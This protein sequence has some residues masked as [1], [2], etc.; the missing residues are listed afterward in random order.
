MYDKYFILLAKDSNSF[1]SHGKS[2]DK[3]RTFQDYYTEYDTK[4]N[5]K[6]ITKE[7]KEIVNTFEELVR[8]NFKTINGDNYFIYNDRKS[9]FSLFAADLMI[10][11]EGHIKLIELNYKIGTK[12]WKENKKEMYDF[13][14]WIYENGIKPME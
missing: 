4:L 6:S 7:I 14:N 10:T 8:L 2:T 13:F 12:F 5:L 3:F 11:K 1:D 9:T